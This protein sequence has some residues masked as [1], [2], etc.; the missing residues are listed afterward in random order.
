MGQMSQMCIQRSFSHSLSGNE[1][2]P[3][4]DET[5]W[6]K[7]MESAVRKIEPRRM[8]CPLNGFISAALQY[9]WAF[10][11]RTAPPTLWS[12]YY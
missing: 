8:K 11:G 5:L 9:L 4:N 12:W 3:L 10:G 2:L 6:M 1:T 7:S